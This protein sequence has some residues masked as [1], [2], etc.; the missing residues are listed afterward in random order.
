LS[1]QWTQKVPSVLHT[2]LVLHPRM[3]T[4]TS[5]RGMGVG[6]GVGVGAGV[7]VGVG[8]GV[9]LGVG[10]GVGVGA[11]VGPGVGGGVG[12]GDADA[13]GVVGSPTFPDPAFASASW[14]AAS[15]ACH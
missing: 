4:E 2:S 7:G 13:H 3:L 8:V 1:N 12:L 5:G 11:G 10:V 15:R 6:V 9:G 14:A